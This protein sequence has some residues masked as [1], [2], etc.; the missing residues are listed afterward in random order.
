MQLV[1][2]T[3]T[4]KGYGLTPASGALDV[5]NPD[6]TADLAGNWPPRTAL[7][8][9]AR[10]LEARARIGAPLTL[11]SCDNIPANGR[12]LR[13][14]LMGLIEATRPALLD[15]VEANVAFPG[16]MVDRIVPAAQAEDV[17]ALEATLGAT[18]R[19]RCLASRSGNG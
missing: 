16:T 2:L 4:E 14:A 13:T 8:L 6:V 15:W 9:L 10:A 18:T 17:D 5:S 11:M 1:T 7:G 12:R 3:I 19:R